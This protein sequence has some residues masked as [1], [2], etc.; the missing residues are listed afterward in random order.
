MIFGQVDEHCSWIPNLE[1]IEAGSGGGDG[2]GE[3]ES[4][5]SL[6]ELGLTRHEADRGP[7]PE[8]LDQP[9]RVLFEW[10][11][12]PGPA[13]RERFLLEE[14]LLVHGWTGMRT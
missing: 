14:H 13:D 5:P 9:G 4:E 7:S 2:E 3:I 1:G 6:S 12:I 11:E 8:R 10:S